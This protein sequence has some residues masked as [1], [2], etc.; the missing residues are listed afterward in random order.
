MERDQEAQRLVDTLT[1]R[2]KE[3]ACLL[4]EG[5]TEPQVAERLCRSPNTVDQ[6]V[7]AIHRRLGCRCRARLV[8]IVLRAGLCDRARK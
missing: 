7:Q 5:L 8:A 3:V 6:H 1:N 4:A 2:Q